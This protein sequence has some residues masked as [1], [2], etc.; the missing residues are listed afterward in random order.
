MTKA[1]LKATNPYVITTT[2]PLGISETYTTDVIDTAGYSQVDWIVRADQDSA[3]L[4]VAF[5]WS[6]DGLAPDYIEQ[7]ADYTGTT[8]HGTLTPKARYLICVYVN[9]GVANSLFRHQVVLKP[10]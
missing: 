1:A 8:L 9:G 7:N 10:F 3:V 5:E 2:T 6:V 4:G